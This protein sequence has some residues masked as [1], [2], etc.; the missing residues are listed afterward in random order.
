MQPFLK[1]AGGKRWL[2]PKIKDSI[3][4]FKTYFEPF[5]GSGT[6]FFAL[7]PKSAVL[8]DTNPELVNCYKVIKNHCEPMIK[9]LK[10][11]KF[12]K[13]DYYAIRDKFQSGNDPIKRAAYFIYLNKTCWNGLY[14][15]NNLGKF[16]VPIGT[17]LSR[18]FKVYDSDHLKSISHLLK[19]AII[20]R[21]DFEETVKQARSGDLVYFDPPY[22]TT[23]LKNGFIKYNSVLFHQSDELRLAKLAEKLANRKIQVILSNAAHPLIKQQYN[24]CF[25]KTEILRPSLIAAD[26]E[27]RTKFLELLVTSFPLIQT[28]EPD[29]NLKRQDEFISLNMRYKPSYNPKCRSSG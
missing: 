9:V 8:S 26:P 28:I 22:I 18:G 14:R 2:I 13:S 5:L 4:P 19:R 6:L 25:Y 21:C 24:G 16:N 7:E 15:V 1:W 17:H 10:K 29:R 3:P 20:K 27:K 23:H 11:L 12:K